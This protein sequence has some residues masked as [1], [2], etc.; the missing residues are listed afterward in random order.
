MIINKKLVGI[1]YGGTISPEKFYPD[2]ITIEVA[3]YRPWIEKYI[4]LNLPEEEYYNNY[5]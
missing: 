2:Q 5:L 4:D 1:T 3:Y